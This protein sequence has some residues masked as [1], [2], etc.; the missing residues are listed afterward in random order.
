MYRISLYY[1]MDIQQLT[2]F[3]RVVREGSFS[4]AAWSLNVSQPT[5]SARIQG[6]ETAVGGALF[7]RGRKVALTER[8]I[9]FLPYARRLLVTWRDGLEATRFEGG[10]RGRLSIGALR[11]LMGSFF[12]AA[13]A[14]FHALYPEV[15]GDIRGG[16]QWQLMELLADD[17]IE[18][19]IICWPLENS[20]LTDVTP[21]FT[22]HEPI[23]L[24]VRPE[25]PLTELKTV[26]RADLLAHAHPFLLLRWWQT[27][28]LELTTL[29][30]Q[31]ERVMDVPAEAGRIMI[32]ESAGAGF[33]PISVVKTDLERGEMREIQVV[34]LPAQHR[35]LALVH[36]ARRP[37]RSKSA[38]RMMALLLEQHSVHPLG[39]LS[40]IASNELNTNQSK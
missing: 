33:F 16:D 8:G 19:A 34:D 27:T 22:I 40:I 32:L 17:V 21:L 4:R 10:N 6:L 13:L 1:C 38:E 12:G 31:A 26:T 28:P 11:S 25:H 18:L 36:L 2:A 9:N 37:E 39:A 5:I 15:E 7:R 14:K 35:D 23:V 3:E 29:A 24:V 30:S 20:L